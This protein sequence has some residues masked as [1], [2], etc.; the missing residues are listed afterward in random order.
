MKKVDLDKTY[1]KTYKLNYQGRSYRSTLPPE[2][3]KKKAKE[4]G[5]SVEEFIENYGVRIHF[6]A[7]DAGDMILEFVKLGEKP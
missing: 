5:L 3:I 1:E 7:F 2:V 6:N 4:V